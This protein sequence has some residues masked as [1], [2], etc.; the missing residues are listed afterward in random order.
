MTT[1]AY[2]AGII[3]S[4]TGIVMGGV[5]IRGGLHKICATPSGVLAGASGDAVY[6]QQFI[7]WVMAGM[8]DTKIPTGVEEEEF[9]DRGMVI[10]RDDVI[11]VY[12]P[13]GWYKLHGVEFLAIG[14]GKPVAMGAMHRGASATEAV[15]VAMQYD[16]NTTGDVDYLRR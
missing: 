7:D 1:I 3:A 9:I 10:S 5:I 6:C 4:D 16:I 8:D 14:S 2:R 11:T 12:E 13:R 15:R